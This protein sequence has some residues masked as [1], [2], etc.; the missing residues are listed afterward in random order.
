MDESDSD[1]DE[2]DETSSISET[3]ESDTIDSTE[4]SDEEEEVITNGRT[5]S[6]RHNNG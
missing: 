5:R 2:E 6:T 4:I 1:M 3:E